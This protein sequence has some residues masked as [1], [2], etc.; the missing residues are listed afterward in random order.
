M[1]NFAARAVERADYALCRRVERV[2]ES[3]RIVDVDVVEFFADFFEVRVFDDVVAEGCSEEVFLV[4]EVVDERTGLYV[5]D[6]RD[7]ADCRSR[8][9]SVGER[10]ARRFEEL[11]SFSCA[12]NIRALAR[13]MVFCHNSSLVLV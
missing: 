13:G 4:V 9:A 12:L 11:S 7:V 1:R 3:L 6:F 10:L 8:I 2:R 5:C